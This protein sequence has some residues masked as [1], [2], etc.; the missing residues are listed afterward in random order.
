MACRKNA[1]RG[2][3]EASEWNQK[4][5]E[6]RNVILAKEEN[7]QRTFWTPTL[8]F[9]ACCT[10]W[11]KHGREVYGHTN[12]R[13]LIQGCSGGCGKDHP[14]ITLDYQKTEG[15][16]AVLSHNLD[17]FVKYF[18][19]LVSQNLARRKNDNNGGNFNNERCYF[20]TGYLSTIKENLERSTTNF[21]SHLIKVSPA[22]LAASRRAH[23]RYTEQEELEQEFKRRKITEQFPVV[24]NDLLVSVLDV[25]HQHCSFRDHLDLVEIAWMRIS[26]KIFARYAAKTASSRIRQLRL[27]YSVL[28]EGGTEEEDDHR[29]DVEDQGR[30]CYVVSQYC[31]RNLHTV[32]SSRL[33]LNALEN[34]VF[35]P[36]D[37]TK[38][39]DF[40]VDEISSDPRLLIRVYLEGGANT[41]LSCLPETDCLYSDLLEV[42]R[43]YF[44][45]CEIDR[46]GIY[47]SSNFKYNVRSLTQT[48]GGKTGKFS[49]QSFQF[50]FRDFLGIYVRKKLPKAKENLQEIKKKRPI[51][52]KEYV[53]AIAKAARESPGNS[54]AFQGMK[55]W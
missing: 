3:V 44:N 7:E 55:G 9:D 49:L 25:C 4:Q 47:T 48:D 27:S 12:N 45:P 37:E 13:A 51:T 34:H 28:L 30:N 42:A 33:P 18:D 53:K 46:E 29:R 38:E 17:P 10:Q 40:S 43:F 23:E 35:V 36:D 21:D 19:S 5:Q 20:L 50:E 24:D 22:A 52:T 39:F 26:N 32:I 8:V 6:E 54:Q 41:N 15:A 11:L 1:Y 2:M 14:R 31:S 16:I